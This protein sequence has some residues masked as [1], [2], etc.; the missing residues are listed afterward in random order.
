M[1]K[2]QLRT[3]IESVL[4]RLDDCITPAK[5]IDS[6]LLLCLFFLKILNAPEDDRRQTCY[7]CN[8]QRFFEADAKDC[9]RHMHRSVPVCTEFSV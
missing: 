3:V 7:L 6:L 9:T 5:A 2:F 8:I 1:K 4:E